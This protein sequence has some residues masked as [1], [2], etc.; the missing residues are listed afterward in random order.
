[1]KSFASSRALVSLF[2][3]ASGAL[4]GCKEGGADSVDQATQLL[5]SDGD[6]A[7]AADDQST[8][9]LTDATFEAA[10]S[11]D[12]SA[13]ATALAAAPSETVDAKCRSRRRD[14]GD[15]STVIITLTDCTGR[16]GVHHVSGTEIVHF[17]QGTGGVLHADFHSEGLTVDG[18]AA[19]HTASAD[20]TFQGT[21]RH[22]AWQ[23]SWDATTAGGEAAAHTSDLSIDVDT[24]THCRTRNGTAVTT[25]GTREVDS[26]IQGLVTCRDADGDAGC[27]TGTVTHTGKVNGKSVTVAFDGSDQATITTPKGISFERPLVCHE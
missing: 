11:A 9:S 15:P 23:G 17:T 6:S 1:M 7:V 25:I 14:P 10:P 3:V 26:S 12:P 18:R 4:A 27:P 22:V 16:F 5:S 2:L 8:I 21:S 24:A 19:T 20:I 13:A